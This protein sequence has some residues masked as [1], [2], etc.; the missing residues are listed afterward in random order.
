[1]LTNHLNSYVQKTAT[2]VAFCKRGNGLIKINGCPLHLVEPSTLRMK[3]CT[4]LRHTYSRVISRFSHKYASIV[5]IVP[6][7]V[8]DMNEIADLYNK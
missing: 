5:L 6:A 8:W 2:A 4:C 1:M 3:V 7:L